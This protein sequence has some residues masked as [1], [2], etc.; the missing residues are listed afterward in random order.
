ML[1]QE[2]VNAAIQVAI[3][4][5]IALLVW[6]F[7][8]RKRAGFFRY[9]GLI[10]PT[11]RSMGLALVIFALWSLVTAIIYFS[12]EFSDAASAGNTVAG[13]IRAQGF[14]TE[15]VLLILI[16]A[17]VKTALSEEILFRGV[18][19]KRLIGVFGF[20]VGNTIH[21]LVFGG[22]HLLIFLVPGG[23]E[24]TP[25]LGAAFLLL[26]GTAG[27][28]MALANEKLGNG[29]IA[30]GWLIHAMGNAIS[31]PILAFVA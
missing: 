12:P 14:G 10:L 25:V 26:P 29:S 11:M 27:W 1:T 7:W 17:G 9:S 31:Y 23:P 2:V 5:V 18:L 28:L 13:M 21:A 15:T 20:W 19:A 16:I 4:L 24:F 8:G 6:L 3:A 30:P 22:I